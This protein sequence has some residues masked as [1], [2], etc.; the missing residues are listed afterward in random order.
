MSTI[1]K[2]NSAEVR[3]PLVIASKWKTCKVLLRDVG[4][5][6]VDE[7]FPS[8]LELIQCKISGTDIPSIVSQSGD[9]VHLSDVDSCV[10]TTPSSE[11]KSSSLASDHIVANLEESPSATKWYYLSEYVD[12]PSSHSD[13]ANPQSY[14]KEHA[15]TINGFTEH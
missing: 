11:M 9:T 5:D 6:G 13:L 15:V 4:Y 14:T 2:R 8:L 3:V 1:S 7:F 10:R 12:A